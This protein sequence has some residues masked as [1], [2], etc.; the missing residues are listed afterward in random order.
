MKTSELKKMLKKR[1]CFIIEHGKKHDLW[2]SPITGKEF[3]VGRH[4]AKE[5]A[6]GTVESILK[7][8]GIK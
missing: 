7:D 2:Y 5:V 4:P 1:G 3:R 6:N 8:A